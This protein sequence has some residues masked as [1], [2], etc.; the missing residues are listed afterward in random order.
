MIVSNASIQ[1]PDGIGIETSRA[2]CTTSV[3]PN[4]ARAA[5]GSYSSVSFVD[6][7]TAL[8]ARAGFVQATTVSATLGIRRA[9]ATSASVT[10]AAAPGVSVR[11]L[12]QHSAKT[13]AA[14]STRRK[15]SSHMSLRLNPNAST[16]VV[17]IAS[18]TIRARSI[19]ATGRSR[20]PGMIRKS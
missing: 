4:V 17:S 5:L 16:S 19:I 13:L 3:R 20:E 1:N 10:L 8:A 7:A 2:G 11:S 12:P 9:A 6:H 15:T 18:A 14:V